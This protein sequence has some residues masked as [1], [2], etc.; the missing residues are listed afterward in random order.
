M[1]P[2]GKVTSKYGSWPGALTQ[3]QLSGYPGSRNGI[4]T[5]RE[6]RTG[7]NLPPPPR[8]RQSPE[9]SPVLCPA[10][11]SNHLQSHLARRQHA[12][13]LWNFISSSAT[14]SF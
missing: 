8:G 10:H 1:V 6:Q 12:F 13:T 5:A 9:L 7:Q 2:N 3:P 4:A 11:T 14:R